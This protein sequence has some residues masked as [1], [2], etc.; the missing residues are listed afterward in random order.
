MVTG[1]KICPIN[2]CQQM[3]LTNKKKAID[4]NAKGGDF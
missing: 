3:A 1:N 2:D 4:N